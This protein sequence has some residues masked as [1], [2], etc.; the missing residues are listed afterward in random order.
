MLF[1]VIPT[2]GLFFCHTSLCKDIP[3]SADLRAIDGFR[4]YQLQIR[5]I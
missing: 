1:K 2:F 4:S 3:M 5:F